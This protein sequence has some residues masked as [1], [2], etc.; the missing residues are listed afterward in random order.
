M[1]RAEKSTAEAEEVIYVR[2]YQIVSD[3]AGSEYPPTFDMTC[4]TIAQV[5]E[6]VRSALTARPKR[7]LWITCQD[8]ERK[9]E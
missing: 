8:Q 5:A 6:A 3:D 1:T 2:R 7:K 9:K 4:N